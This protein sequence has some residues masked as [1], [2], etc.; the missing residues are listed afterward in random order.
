MPRAHLG[1]V[2]LPSG[3]LVV[4]DF[5]CLSLFGDTPTAIRASLDASL[6]S[7]EALV[8]LGGLAFVVVRD[9][10]RGRFAVTTQLHGPGELLGQ[11]VDVRVE[12]TRA[13]V[14]S[15]VPLGRMLVDTARAGFFDLDA[16]PHWNEHTPP[17]GL[18]DVALWG[19]DGDAVAARV[20]A[21]PAARGT[22]AFVGLPYNDALAIAKELQA[23][24]ESRRFRFAFDFR[25]HTHPYFLLAQ[26]RDS[27]TQ[28]GTI[29]V[30][31][32]SVCGWLTT[33][34]DGWF[35][36]ELELDADGEPCGVRVD[37]VSAD[38]G[39]ESQSREKPS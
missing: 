21:P 8:H 14:A 33:W 12:L 20:G 7:G 37:F 17:N 30:G 22:H 10:P 34:G 1:Q 29:E 11:R 39:G 13:E 36:V 18:A 19:A 24:R 27:V 26:L 31:R 28:G 32:H 25:P 23:L 38:G 35:P 4:V 15:R 9:L 2:D 6:A 16:L 5:G 3:T